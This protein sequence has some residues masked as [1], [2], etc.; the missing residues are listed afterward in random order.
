MGKLLKRSVVQDKVSQVCAKAI[1]GVVQLTTA[2]VGDLYGCC[3]VVIEQVLHRKRVQ[4]S[5]ARSASS[6]CWQDV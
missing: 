4:V 6:L 3:I 1:T 5:T 2:A